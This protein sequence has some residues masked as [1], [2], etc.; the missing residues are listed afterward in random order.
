MVLN[1]GRTTYQVIRE[2]LEGK[3]NTVYICREAGKSGAPYKTVWIVK[4][5]RIVKELLESAANYCGEVF[6]QNAYAGFVFPYFQERPLQKFYLGSIRKGYCTAQQVWL[7]L[8]EQ[9]IISKLPPAVVYLILR[10]K[11][12]QI[13]ADGSVLL[14]FLLDL[15]DYDNT[16]CEQDNVIAC[17]EEIVRLIRLE[18]LEKKNN[19]VKKQ[20]VTLLERKLERD[21]YQEFMQLYR[22]IRLFGRGDSAGKKRRWRF[23]LSEWNWLYRLLSCVCVV[24]VCMVVLMILGNVFFGE[25]FFWKLFCNSLDT[26]GTETLLQ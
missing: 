9:C 1:T 25:D 26:I 10:Q 23:D 24:L 2:V 18:D 11:Q 15:S 5:R 8:V 4:D 13:A 20:A 22:D 19:M 21:E 17:A 12:A 16:I 3:A 6:M 14:G 7:A